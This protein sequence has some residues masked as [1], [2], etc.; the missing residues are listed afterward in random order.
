MTETEANNQLACDYFQ[1]FLQPIR[2]APSS[3]PAQSAR[4]TV[5]M[6]VPSRYSMI[7][8]GGPSPRGRLG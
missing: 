1:A 6:T 7:A 5:S 3:N 8:T 2:T 4:G